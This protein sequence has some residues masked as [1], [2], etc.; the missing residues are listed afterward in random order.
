MSKHKHG[1]PLPILI[2]LSA[3]LSL[4]MWLVFLSVATVIVILFD[5][6]QSITISI[7][8]IFIISLLSYIHHESR[9]IVKGINRFTGLNINFDRYILKEDRI[10]K[11][12]PG[13]FLVMDLITEYNSNVRPNS[14]NI[15]EVNYN[16]V[17]D[18][19]IDNGKVTISDGTTRM[20]FYA[21]D[22]SIDYIE[23]KILHKFL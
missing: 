21:N 14:T 8:D 20:E 15:S 4:I 19:S 16:D 7:F 22:S 11:Y 10:V 9:F 3:H 5:I 13:G 17:K 23:K 6:N 12:R 18:Y 1:I 2:L